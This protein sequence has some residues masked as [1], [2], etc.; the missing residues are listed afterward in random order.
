MTNN[1]PFVEWECLFCRC[2]AVDLARGVI[3]NTTINYLKSRYACIISA[4]MTQPAAAKAPAP[5][6]MGSSNKHSAFKDKTKPAEIRASSI[7][8]AKGGCF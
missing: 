5:S 2:G 6:A 3:F 1:Q 7:T 4:K 8:A